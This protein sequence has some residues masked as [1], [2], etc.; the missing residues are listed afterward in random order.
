MGSE[1]CT[2]A[3][4]KKKWSNIKVDV[5]RR[6]A[7][8]RHAKVWPKQVGGQEKRGP[9]CLNRESAQL[10]VTLLRGKGEAD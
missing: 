3:E 5:K 2:Q 9:P 6:L 1:K 7:A 4:V 8:H 10:W